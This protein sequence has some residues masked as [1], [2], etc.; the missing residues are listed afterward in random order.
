LEHHVRAQIRAAETIVMEQGALL[1][2]ELE[3]VFLSL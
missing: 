1:R 3:Q 2:R